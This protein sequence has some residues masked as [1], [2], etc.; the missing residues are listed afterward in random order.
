MC[1]GFVQPCSSGYMSNLCSGSRLSIWR[2]QVIGWCCW[3]RRHFLYVYIMVCDFVFLQERLFIILLF[4]RCIEALTRAGQTD[5]QLLPKAVS[6]FEVCTLDRC[7][8]VKNLI[9]KPTNVFLFRTFYFI[10]IMLDFA[11]KKYLKLEK[12]AW[13]FCFSST[14]F[15]I[16]KNFLFISLKFGQ[17]CSGIHVSLELLL[18]I[19]D[20]C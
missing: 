17:R 10:S 7:A 19:G 4:I 5:R 13:F 20:I 18:K 16:L 6:M 8:I 12:R 3:R 1:V 2:E 15:V 14:W 9:G 11:P